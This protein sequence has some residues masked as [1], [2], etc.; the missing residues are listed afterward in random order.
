MT[1]GFEKAR[2]AL[3]KIIAY[4]SLFGAVLGLVGTVLVRMVFPYGI[5]EIGAYSFY[6][7]SILCLLFVIA[8]CLLEMA[9]HR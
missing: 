7:L 1:N 2:S 5:L 4:V 6:S 3:M 9:F 8:V